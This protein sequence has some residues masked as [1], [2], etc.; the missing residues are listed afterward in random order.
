MQDHSSE[1]KE[2]N[3][4]THDVHSNSIPHRDVKPV[5]LSYLQK[6]LN[7]IVKLRQFAKEMMSYNFYP[8]LAP[9][10]APEKYDKGLCS[11]VLECC[12]VPPF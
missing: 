11:W 7:T 4:D 10:V 8:L 6:K 3:E 12:H 9:T 2:H 1:N 5:N